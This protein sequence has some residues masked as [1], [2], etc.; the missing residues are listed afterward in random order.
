MKGAAV[1]GL[2]VVAILV[3]AGSGY[4]YGSGNQRI[5]TSVS[6][7]TTTSTTAITYTSTS[8]LTTTSVETTTVWN[9]QTAAYTVAANGLNFSLSINATALAPNQ[10]IEI[11][12]SLYNTLPK[13]NNITASVNDY[14]FLG[15]H[16]FPGPAG[17]WEGPYLFVVLNGSYTA[18]GLTGL[19]G[20]GLAEGGVSMESAMPWSYR[21]RPNSSNATLSDYV[22]TANCYNTTAGPYLST[23]S[24]VVRGYWAVP[25]KT[26]SYP[27]PPYAFLPGVYTVA[28]EDEWGAVLVLHFTVVGQTGGSAPFVCWIPDQTCS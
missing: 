22:C 16:L 18:Q 9:T 4:I 26:G 7:T 24:V 13:A 6:N 15:Y 12:A 21:F 28:V 19:G 17:F 8:V 23:A 2:L 25:L 5:L 11:I 1:A 14:Q 20:K 27:S 3:A 10:S